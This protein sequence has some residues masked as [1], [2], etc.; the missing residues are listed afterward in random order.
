[1]AHHRRTGASLFV[2][3]RGRHCHLDVRR[4]VDGRRAWRRPAISPP[5]VAVDVG[6]GKTVTLELR[7][8]DFPPGTTLVMFS[9]L[10][11]RFESG[12]RAV[13]EV[14]QDCAATCRKAA[15]GFHHSSALRTASGPMRLHASR[16]GTPVGQSGR[17]TDQGL[18]HDALRS[19]LR[20]PLNWGCSRGDACPRASDRR[21]AGGGAGHRAGRSVRR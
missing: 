2:P 11:G 1:M 18:S 16:E 6:P 10:P 13:L 12:Q 4:L 15:P 5:D 7:H 17:I 19:R 21:N 9:D 8:D 3:R 20:A 14:R